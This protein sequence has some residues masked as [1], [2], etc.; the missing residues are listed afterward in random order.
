MYRK[1]SI[2]ND[3]S[4]DDLKAMAEV[5]K[6]R[7]SRLKDEKF[8]FAPD[9][10]MIDGGHNQVNAVLVEMES[11]GCDIPVCG[12]VK[13]DRH[14]TRALIYDGNEIGMRTDSSL[15]RLIA[16]IQ[17]EA[18]RFAIEFNRKKRRKRYFDSEL[19]NI[20][21]IGAKR[22]EALMKHFGSVREIR[23]AGLTQLEALN[24]INSTV[25]GEIYSYFHGKVVK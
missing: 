16:S 8:G 22:K 2:K 12:M 23:A 21:G 19:D 10:I 11:A 4:Y 7:L 24:G 25:A 1:F 5:I 18:H 13:D 14:I 17:N 20:S 6:R 3:S 9:L 15:F